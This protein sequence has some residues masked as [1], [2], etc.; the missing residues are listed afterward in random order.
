MIQLHLHLDPD[1]RLRHPDLDLGAAPTSR[2]QARS[3]GH[4]PGDASRRG[5]PLSL[6]ASQAP[7]R[8]HSLHLHHSP[9]VDHRAPDLGLVHVTNPLGDMLLD[10]KNQGLAGWPEAFRQRPLA[11][12]KEKRPKLGHHERQWWRPTSTKRH[13]QTQKHW[14]SLV[15]SFRS[16]LCF[17]REEFSA[18]RV[19][20]RHTEKPQTVTRVPPTPTTFPSKGNSIAA[21]R[22]LT[23][24][25]SAALSMVSTDNCGMSF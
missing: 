4:Q 19:V 5:A 11:E 3:S 25:I 9:V 2:P 24:T 10:W 18:Q 7:P 15:S 6:L 20:V 12:P 17:G 14:R 13:S 22:R 16:R 21:S 1:P 23:C 8:R